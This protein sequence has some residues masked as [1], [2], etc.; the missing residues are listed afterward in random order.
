MSDKATE[1]RQ[2][3]AFLILTGLAFLALL[4]LV[5]QAVSLVPRRPEIW[6]LLMVFPVLLCAVG[7]SKVRTPFAYRWRAL[8]GFLQALLFLQYVLPARVGFH[9]PI[10]LT[11]KAVVWV[12]GYTIVFT[13]ITAAVLWARSIRY[14]EVARECA[15]CGYSLRGLRTPRCPECGS[16]FDPKLIEREVT[17]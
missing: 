5:T 15:Q 4:I 2:F 17:D 8:S 11:A 16:P 13:S 7:A 9:N 6:H 3:I 1:R 10:V 14:Q 12:L